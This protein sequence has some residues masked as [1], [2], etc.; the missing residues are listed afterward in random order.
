MTFQDRNIFLNVTQTKALRIPL[1]GMQLFQMRVMSRVPLNVLEVKKNI[2]QQIKSDFKK[3][4]IM[5]VLNT[6]NDYTESSLKLVFTTNLTVNSFFSL[7]RKKL[8]HL[9]EIF[10]K[11][12]PAQKKA[13]V[14]DRQARQISKAIYIIFFLIR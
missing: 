1:R 5:S 13:L 3:C 10:S 4:P 9:W 7:I 14:Y 8:I 6:L 2:F 12:K 11:V